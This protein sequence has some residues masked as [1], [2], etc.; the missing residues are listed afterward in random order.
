[1]VKIFDYS[2][3]KARIN[4]TRV[5]PTKVLTVPQWTGGDVTIPILNIETPKKALGVW[6]REN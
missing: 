1:M 4:K 5:L 3:G 2:S 6:S